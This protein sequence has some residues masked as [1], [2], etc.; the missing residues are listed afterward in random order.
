MIDVLNV[1]GYRATV[2]YDP[3]I[4]MF[5]GEFLGLNGGA[6]FYADTVK[7]LKREAERS[8]NAFISVCK[9]RGLPV[10]RDYSGRFNVRVAPQLH[11]KA[12]LVAKARKVSLNKLVEQALE[13]QLSEAS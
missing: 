11:E 3:E 10:K 9:E 7:G 6:D 13:A 1:N 12:V 4:D 5:R 2:K 8:L